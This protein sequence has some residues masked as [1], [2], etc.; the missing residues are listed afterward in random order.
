MLIKGRL[1]FLDGRAAQSLEHVPSLQGLA[2]GRLG[3][4]GA[5]WKKP[6]H[7]GLYPRFWGCPLPQYREQEAW[8]M[9]EATSE[10]RRTKGKCPE[11]P[12]TDALT[13][14]ARRWIWLSQ[15]Q[16]SVMPAEQAV[17]RHAWGLDSVPS[18]PSG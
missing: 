9:G 16:P 3:E 2:G 1:H 14:K 6:R 18:A 17:S 13:P 4:S 11:R 15:T 7:P 5:T 10:R 12:V 8:M